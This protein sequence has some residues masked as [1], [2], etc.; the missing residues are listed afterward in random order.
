[1][2]QFFNESMIQS[3]LLSPHYFY[4][5]E[6]RHDFVSEQ[7]QVVAGLLRVARAGVQIKSHL[8]QAEPVVQL[9]EAA[10]A[11]GRRAHHGAPFQA[12]GAGS[13]EVQKGLERIFSAKLSP[14]L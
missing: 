7:L 5:A 10:T 12:V 8:I 4:L 11:C 14:S 6:F 1:M 2:S 9:G 13:D 3:C